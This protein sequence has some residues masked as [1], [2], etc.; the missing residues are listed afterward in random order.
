MK[1][2][3]RILP[4]LCLLSLRPGASAWPV[5]VVTGLGYQFGDYEVDPRFQSD[6]RR[7]EA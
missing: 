2:I 5:A 1:L 6:I 4:A 7:R 3:Q